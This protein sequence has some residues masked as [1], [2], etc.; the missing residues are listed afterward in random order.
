MGRESNN[1]G[2]TDVESPFT[3]AEQL[4]TGEV[5]RADVTDPTRA[6]ELLQQVDTSAELGTINR[7]TIWSLTLRDR[8]TYGIE[9]I[10]L[11]YVRHSC[12]F[13]GSKFSELPFLFNSAVSGDV[14]SLC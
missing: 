14:H 4:G 1:C 12:Y 10:F 8:C 3:R 11:I 2:R 6:C 7:L 5:F 9:T 13:S